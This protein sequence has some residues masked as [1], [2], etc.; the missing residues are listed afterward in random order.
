LS[1]NSPDRVSE[2]ALEREEKEFQTVT[3][4]DINLRSSCIDCKFVM[5]CHVATKSGTP[6]LDVL[7][8]TY[9]FNALE[10]RC[11]V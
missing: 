11:L 10:K 2:K 8:G 6:K 4:L 9:R 5:S 3:E 7:L 1:R